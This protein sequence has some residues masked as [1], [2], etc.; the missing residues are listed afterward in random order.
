METDTFD[1]TSIIPNQLLAASFHTVANIPITTRPKKKIDLETLR[2]TISP[3]VPFFLKLLVLNIE[4]DCHEKNN[5]DDIWFENY[6]LTNLDR[7]KA[8]ELVEEPINNP[9]MNEVKLEHYM[10]WIPI[11]VQIAMMEEFL[12]LLSE[13]LFKITVPVYEKIQQKPLYDSMYRVNPHVKRSIT[14]LVMRLSRLQIETLAFI[15]IHILHLWEYSMCPQITKVSICDFFGPLIIGFQSRVLLPIDS[16]NRTAEAAFLTAILDA[17]NSRVWNNYGG[18]NLF[19]LFKLLTPFEKKRLCLKL[20]P[21]VPKSSYEFTSS[22][23]K[24]KNL[25]DRF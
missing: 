11:R 10:K 7:Q 25:H 1:E 4:T 18:G 12:S 23:K 13:K 22:D 17:T 20:T 3:Y 5:D 14:E 6:K 2:P 9:S 8:K 19:T 15:M 16:V 21:M 24:F